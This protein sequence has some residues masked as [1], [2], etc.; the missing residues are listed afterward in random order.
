MVSLL[1]HECLAQLGE[2]FLD[3]EGVMGSSPLALTIAKQKRLNKAFFL[4]CFALRKTL[5]MSVSS[6]FDT[7]QFVLWHHFLHLLPASINLIILTE[8]KLALSLARK[9]IRF[10]HSSV[11]PERFVYEKSGWRLISS[12]IFPGDPAFTST[13]YSDTSSAIAFVNDTTA[14]LVIEQLFQTALVLHMNQN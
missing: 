4:L 10:A 7:I 2:H 14:P 9:T 11:L 1:M 5:M 12:L 6:V 3:V 8:N 13:L